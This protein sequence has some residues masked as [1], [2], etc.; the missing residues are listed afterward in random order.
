VG[1]A[2]ALFLTIRW[3]WDIVIVVVLMGLAVLLARLANEDFRAAVANT[4]LL[5]AALFVIVLT[6]VGVYLTSSVR[7]Q[8]LPVPVLLS[9]GVIG[10]L[11]A[12]SWVLLNGRSALDKP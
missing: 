7:Q 8:W 1:I 3:P 9:I 5:Y 11:L 2:V 12:G 10:L 6:G 4:L